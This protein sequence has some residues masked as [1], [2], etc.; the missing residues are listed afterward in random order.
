MPRDVIPFRTG[1]DGTAAATD[2]QPNLA[3]ASLDLFRRLS[4]ALAQA[5]NFRDAVRTLERRTSRWGVPA[6]F[7][8]AD[9]QPGERQP[10]ARNELDPRFRNTAARSV[11]DAAKAWDDLHGLLDDAFTVCAADIS[12]RHAARAVP[13]LIERLGDLANDHR[14]CAALAGLLGVADSCPVTVLHP[15][16]GAGFR[17][18]LSGIADLDQFHVLLA[19]AVA[20]APTRGYISGPRPDPRLVDACL[21]EPT[22]PEA[23]I[24]TARFQFL[25]TSAIRPDGTM[26]EGFSASDHWLW[27]HES[28]LAIPTFEGERVLLLADATYPRQWSVRR[29]YPSLHGGLELLHV[30]Q[31]EQVA[32]WMDRL[33]DRRR[34]DRTNRRAA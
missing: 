27:G 17:F 13:E 4:G 1:S 8:L 14:G 30:L 24:A 19:D 21:D 34:M 31:R 23:N 29:R 11:P 7:F 10:S 33:S 3:Y 18:Q 25:K 20:G 32:D 15:A 5:T 9:S 12:V 26:M 16:A 2:A 6:L 22:D 28:P